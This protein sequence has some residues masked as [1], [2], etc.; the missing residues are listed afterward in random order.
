MAKKS[1]QTNLFEINTAAIPD[2]ASL[3]GEEEKPETVLKDENSEAE[4]PDQTP[5]EKQE[6]NTVRVKKTINRHKMRRILSE[7]NLEKELPWHFSEGDT[8]HCLSWG[9]V[10]SL[11]YFRAVVKQQHIKY[12]L[13]STWCMAMED[14]REM[15]DWISRGYVDRPRDIRRRI[16]GRDRA[17]E[18]ARRQALHLPESLEGDGP[19]RGPVR[20]SDRKLGQRQHKP[21]N[22]ANSH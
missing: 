14:L 6:F 20:R 3:F 9:D 7:A 10:D 8:F 12:A 15:D 16:R 2:M 11:T 13:I 19:H 4:G 5:L 1:I 21:A 18:K 17:R 22:R